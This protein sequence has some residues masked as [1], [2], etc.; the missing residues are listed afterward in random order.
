MLR[1]NAQ[2]LR[3]LVDSV[4]GM[5]L[6]IDAAGQQEY[7]NKRFLDYAGKT[8]IKGLDVSR[9]F[10]RTIKRPV[11]SDGSGVWPSDDL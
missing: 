5:I 9:S 11:N 6:V 3:Q 8:E 2:E 4:P 10:T 1:E 7:A